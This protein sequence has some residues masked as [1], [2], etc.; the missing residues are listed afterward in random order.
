MMKRLRNKRGE[1]YI[2]V[3]VTIMIVSFVLVFAVNMVSLVS[4]TQNIKVAA[5]QLVEYASLNGTTDIDE[6]AEKLK[7]KL[8]VDF[9]YSFSGT[10]YHNGTTHVQLGDRI[11][12]T[13]TYSLRIGGFG[14]F[15][16]P[17]TITAGAGGL[18]QVYWR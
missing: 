1:G 2:D 4:L 7:E 11:E 14:E 10:T 15:I 8:G 13:V 9:T 17:L 18:S 3:A 16:Q 12:C 5:D 6:Y